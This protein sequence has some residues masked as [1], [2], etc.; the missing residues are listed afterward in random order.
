MNKAAD[1]EVSETNF[2]DKEDEVI[3]LELYFDIDFEYLQS[4]RGR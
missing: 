4:R 2:D 3:E 1:D